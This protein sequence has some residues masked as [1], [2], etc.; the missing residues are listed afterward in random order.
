MSKIIHRKFPFFDIEE[1]NKEMNSDKNDLKPY[2]PKE[3][4]SCEDFIFISAKD[5]NKDKVLKLSKNVKLGEF[6]CFTNSID[7]FLIK[8]R[9]TEK[10]SEKFLF[11]FGTDSI[12]KNPVKENEN[13]IST[14]TN[15]SNNNDSS[16]SILISSL[17]IYDLTDYLT[18]DP[19]ITNPNELYTI[20]LRY[21]EDKN[22]ISITNSDSD[23]KSI[24]S[25]INISNFDISDDM[26]FCAFT[27]SNNNDL[28]IVSCNNN[29]DL[30][31]IKDL[32]SLKFQIVKRIDF[33]NNDEDNKNN[34]NKKFPEITNIGFAHDKN[35][36][37]I[38]YYSTKKGVY[39]L[40]LNDLIV[41]MVEYADGAPKNCLSIS[42]EEN[43]FY[44]EIN[45]NDNQCL[46]EFD[47]FEQG[48]SF[49]LEG[50]KKFLFYFKKYYGYILEEEN[51]NTLAIYDSAN[52]MFV[53]SHSGFGKIKAYD[54]DN[55][56]IYILGETSDKK[57]IVFKLKEKDNKEK[58]DSF[59]KKG[60]YDTAFKYA[61]NL[62]YDD[63]KK[64]EISLR[65]AKYL[66]EK[67]EYEKS[68][69]QYVNT[70]N[71]QD[72][73]YVIQ[74]FL[75]GSKLD[76][77]IK[78]LEKL[79]DNE[80]FKKNCDS[81]QL[82]DYTALLLNCYIKQKQTQKLKKFVDDK[83]LNDPISIK[84]AIEVCK[85]TKEYDLA[86][87]IAKN[88]QMTEAYIQILM[89]LKGDYAES[90]DY[91][92]GV[93]NIV[94]KYNLILKYGE[95]FLEKQPT[96][97]SDVITNLINDIIDIKNFEF[98]KIN[99]E[100]IQKK[101]IDQLPNEKV[102]E[103]PDIKIT[104]EK[105]LNLTP[106]EIKAI[107]N[108]KYEK[109]INIFVVK[110]TDM[111]DTRENSPRKMLIKILNLMMEKDNKCPCSI[112]VR[113]IELYVDELVQSKES[114]NI[115]DEM[116]KIFENPKFQNIDKSYILMLF[117]VTKF[118]LGIEKLTELMN[119]NDELCQIYM[120]NHEYP[121]LLEFCKRKKNEPNGRNFII[122][123]LCYLIHNS[124][125]AT[126]NYTGPYIEKILD[127]IKGD[128]GFN[129]MLLLQIIGKGREDSYNNKVLEFKYAK[130][131]IMEWLINQQEQLNEDR[132]ICLSNVEKIQK[133]N[134]QIE[135]L[136]TK[137]KSFS[138]T[139]CLNCKSQLKPPFFFFACNHAF[140]SEC[141]KY[142][143]DDEDESISC[144]SCKKEE[145]NL[146]DRIEQTKALAK[147]SN[148][149]FT[150]LRG[151]PKKFN[152]FAE[153]LGKGIFNYLEKDDNKE[154]NTDS[155]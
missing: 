103:I 41:K 37:N 70:I 51:N 30:T 97:T 83:K 7:K 91:L 93:K 147:D 12:N 144:L 101:Q 42:K 142:S 53:C 136:K 5:G 119:L 48:P 64:S 139:K 40:Y 86:L 33:E 106:N 138:M 43:K 34:D 28:I 18:T 104:D 35:N 94:A 123:A 99:F 74:R 95:K 89:D 77:L 146:L 114:A 120:D 108:L 19:S 124:Q 22:G 10:N 155:Y 58:F 109:I 150:E 129:P 112:A 116:K 128:D 29:N 67:G 68:I 44:I 98:Y 82:K 115:F 62:N 50:K 63:K 76:F 55:N 133:T 11:V 49:F 57:K 54:I 85:D 66:Y 26:M 25:F 105:I 8:K 121:K 61:K 141:Y 24:H 130:K 137:A 1:G 151:K 127:L 148:S 36:N 9:D 125:E 52:E 96:E 13:E 110:D 31:K 16:N 117:K 90:L 132:K 27:S 153:F 59:Y 111:Y 71:Y 100:D 135:E 73:S 4:K 3:L 126:K 118:N 102:K 78:Y 140:C 72:P 23:D 21:K 17:K 84:T 88:A 60:L 45:S 81:E 32:K 75:E 134:N 154:I 46:K 122:Q 149:F 15:Q 145:K 107:E 38:L 152:L 113:R 14:S 131:Y 87:T 143:Y 2:I 80:T 20:I 6:E 56:Y 65:H 47:N 39:Y 69:E 92:K 79:L